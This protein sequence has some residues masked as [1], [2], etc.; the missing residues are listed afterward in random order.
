MD[1]GSNEVWMKAMRDLIV[2]YKLHHTFWDINPDSGDTGGLLM[3]DWV[4]WDEPKYALLK[5]SL[6]Q[7]AGGKFVGL[8]HKV[9]LGATGLSVTDY[10]TN[11]GVEPVGQ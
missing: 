3:N 6:W 7:N 2:Q 8:D 11:G 10:Y 4:S 1:G 5:P 9:G